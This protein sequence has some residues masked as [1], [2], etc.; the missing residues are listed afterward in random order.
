MMRTQPR[1][2]LAPLGRSLNLRETVVEKL[3]T[4]IITGE[5]KEGTVVSAPALGAQLGVSATPVREAMM[6][7]ARDGLVETM[8]NKGFRVTTVTDEELMSVTEVRLLIEPPTVARVAGHMPTAAIIELRAIADRNVLAAEQE[9]LQTY[10]VTDRDLHA[11]ILEHAGNSF[12]EELATS[13]RR[14]TR[15]YGLL[16]LADA[17]VLSESAREHHQ[18]IDLIEAGDGGGAAELARR[19]IGHSIDIWKTGETGDPV[20]PPERLPSAT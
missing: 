15:M 4:A 17:G 20:T 1:R 6:D 16:R 5:L 19:H 18:L 8:K 3:R 11:L 2:I 10:L 9:D 7:L 14:R 12:L 13:L